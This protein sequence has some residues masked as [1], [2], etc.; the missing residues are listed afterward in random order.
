[1]GR[2][3]A[4]GGRLGN[5]VVEAKVGQ[6]AGQIQAPNSGRDGGVKGE[7]PR[8]HRGGCARRDRQRRWRGELPAQARGFVVPVAGSSVVLIGG[9]EQLQR[10][11]QEGKTHVSKVLTH[12]HHFRAERKGY[13]MIISIIWK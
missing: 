6:R 10:P 5:V 3:G 4:T 8:L 9:K 13:R 12:E 11:E 7:F 2:R 1:M